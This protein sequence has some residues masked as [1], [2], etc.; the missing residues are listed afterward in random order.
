MK[1]FNP[2]LPDGFDAE[3]LFAQSTHEKIHGPSGQLRNSSTVRFSKNSRGITAHAAPQARGGGGAGT[4]FALLN[5]LH[6]NYLECNPY[7][8]DGS[9]DTGTVINVAKP[10]KLR[11]SVMSATFPNGDIM[12]YDYSPYLPGGARYTGGIYAY[13]RRDVTIAGVSISERQIVVP[14]YLNGDL[15]DPDEITALK[16][17]SSLTVEDDLGNDLTC[18]YIEVGPR[19]WATKANQSS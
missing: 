8:P 7:N 2:S 17:S 11:C 12:T 16:L 10:Y 9:P 6:S 4:L 1:S 5:P 19:H 13:V 14:W 15:N 18:K 3:A